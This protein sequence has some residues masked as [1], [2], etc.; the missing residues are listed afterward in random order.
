MQMMISCAFVGLARGFVLML[1][2]NEEGLLQLNCWTGRLYYRLTHPLIGITCNIK[3]LNNLTSVKGPCVVVVNHQSSLDIFCVQSFVQPH[4]IAIAKKSLKLVPILG[5]FFI[6]ARNIFV[7][8]FNHDK[9]LKALDEAAAQLKKRDAQVVIFPEGT[10]SRTAGEMLP[11]KKGAFNIAVAAQV[12]IIPVVVENQK[13][14]YDSK[15]KKFK[16]GVIRIT[17]ACRLLT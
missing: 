17:S 8:R 2:G 12:P 6:L 11:F 13:H 7:D 3:N 10:R 9:A 15:S 14:V 4:T 16:S 5:W 1:R